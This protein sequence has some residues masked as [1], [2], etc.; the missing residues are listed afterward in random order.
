MLVFTKDNCYRKV[1]KMMRTCQKLK[2][3][4]SL[5]R[6]FNRLILVKTFSILAFAINIRCQN[7]NKYES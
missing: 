1:V 5:Q 4:C 3:C 2:E 7:I 6:T